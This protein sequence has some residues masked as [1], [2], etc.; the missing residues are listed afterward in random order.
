MTS[1]TTKKAFSMSN[2]FDNFNLITNWRA[3]IL[4]VERHPISLPRGSGPTP[5][6]RGSP[7]ESIT[8]VAR[9]ASGPRIVVH[10]SGFCGDEKKM[11][12]IDGRDSFVTVSD[13]VVPVL[14]KSTSILTRPTAVACA[15]FISPAGFARCNPGAFGSER[16]SCQ[17]SHRTAADSSVDVSALRNVCDSETG[18]LL[19]RGKIGKT[20]SGRA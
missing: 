16:E 4:G 11:V 3:P 10:C 13:S 9:C 7:E 15:S 14:Q 5:S 2:V 20:S 1:P 6:T 8:H 18:W 17:T 12:E 19:R